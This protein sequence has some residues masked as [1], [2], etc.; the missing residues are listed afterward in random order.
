EF[1]TLPFCGRWCSRFDAKSE[2]KI[3]KLVRH[4]LVSSYATLVE[5][6]RGC[7]TQSEHTVLIRGK[8]AEILTLG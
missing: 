6:K 3:N 5:V 2:M 7:V 4:G 8:K 1:Q